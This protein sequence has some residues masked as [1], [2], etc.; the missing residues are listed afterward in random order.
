MRVTTNSEYLGAMADIQRAAADLV[1]WQA[2]VSSGR[3]LQTP[4]DDPAAA[5]QSVAEHADVGTMDQY[6]QTA[7]SAKAR[8]TVI[9][10]VLSDVLDRLTSARAD[11]TAAQGSM[12][13]DTQREALAKELEGVATTLLSDVNTT[14]RGTYLFAG[15]AA[16]T[17]PYARQ[18]DGSVSAYQGDGTGVA[19][20]V[21]G[22]RS[23]QVG[24]DGRA[25][26]QGSDA[27]NVFACLSSLAAAIRSNDQAGIASGLDGL[28]RA[29]DR[30]VALQT[31]VGTD[32]SDLDDEEAKLATLKQASVARISTD[33]DANMAEAASNMA[34]A[35]TAYQ[36]ALGAIG[37]RSRLT[38]LDYLQ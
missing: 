7:D 11:A 36:A 33:E 4:S 19:V 35:D 6:V 14:V 3:R 10:S 5:A 9:D 21:D 23:V 12:A 1:K 15:S 16:L 13:T 38:L 30:A 34:K 8:L 20:D 29:V 22:S 17:A 24:F 25:L 31:R 37:A 32:L 28:S 27:Q 26:V 18:A 2:Q